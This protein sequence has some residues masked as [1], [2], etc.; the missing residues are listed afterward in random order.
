M[1]R[2]KVLETRFNPPDLACAEPS[3]KLLY[4]SPERL[5][6]AKSDSTTVDDVIGRNR[7]FRHSS[8]RSCK[9]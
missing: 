3:E 1:G 6:S 7:D 9:S 5:H 8:E 4:S 2:V